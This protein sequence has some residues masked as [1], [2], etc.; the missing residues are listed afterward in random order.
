LRAAIVLFS[1]LA[2]AGCGKKLGTRCT[3]TAECGAG[4]QCI[5]LSHCGSSQTCGGLADGWKVCSQTCMADADCAGLS[6]KPV[7][8][9]VGEPPGRCL[10]SGG[11][12]A[13]G[14]GANPL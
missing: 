5:E 1:V 10:D 7:C 6:E 2:F 11:A 3:E 13:A 12:A 8:S 9:T 4:L 14:L